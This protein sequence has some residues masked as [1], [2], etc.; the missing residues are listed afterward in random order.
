MS[1]MMPSPDIAAAIERLRS[2][3]GARCATGAAVREQHGH[4]VSFHPVH[5]PDAV[6]FVEGPS[7]KAANESVF[8]Q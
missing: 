8:S 5:A 1:A 2:R 4:D 7:D 3:F 6:V